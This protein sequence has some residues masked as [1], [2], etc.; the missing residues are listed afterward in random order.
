MNARRKPD[1]AATALHYSALG[2][3]AITPDPPAA[4]LRYSPALAA[5][6][7]ELL[8]PPLADRADA[9]AEILTA[10]IDSDLF[11][12][13][14]DRG[15]EDDGLWPSDVIVAIQAARDVLREVADHG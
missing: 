9:A 3:Q 11:L 10:L 13:M 2:Q 8:N 1:P 14:L 4:A 15:H 12:R 7:A 5:I 6:A